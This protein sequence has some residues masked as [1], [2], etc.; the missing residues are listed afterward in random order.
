MNITI[1]LFATL[2]D[3]RGKIIE[4]QCDEGT[5]IEAIINDLK[6]DK[7]E[8]AILLKNGINSETDSVL[9]DGD[10]LSIFPPVGG[11]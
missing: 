4:K 10:I 5:N 2:R 1:K 7:K 3:G 11:G 9:K 8:I 6:I